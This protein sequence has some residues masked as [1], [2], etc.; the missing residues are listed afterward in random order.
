MLK[1]RN[2]PC[3]T[4]NRIG[5][6]V[7]YL[8]GLERR[9]R[10]DPKAYPRTPQ[11]E[12]ASE[13]ATDALRYI[14]E[15]NDFAQSRSA[16][17]EHMLVEGLGALEVV[18]DGDKD[19]IRKIRWDRFYH[20]PH[21]M[22]LDLSD[23]LYFGVITWFDQSRLIG[24]YPEMR[25]LIEGTMS[26]A[27]RTYT[28]TYEDKPSGKR[29]VD[30]KRRRIQ[31]FET[32]WW[33]REWQRA[34]WMRGSFLEAAAP[35]PYLDEYNI[36]EHPYVAQCAYRD[37]D[38]NPYGVVKRYKDLQDEIN[39]RRSKALH[40]L[41]ARRVITEQGSVENADMARIE[42]QKP[43]GFLEVAPGARFDIESSVDIGM[44]QF[45]LL[46]DAIQALGTTGPNAALQG[47]SG[48]ISGK[49]KQLDQEGGSVQ[50]GALFD[51]IRHLQKRTAR[52]CW[53]RVKQFWTE[54][55][56][57]R[58]T[59]DEQKVKFVGLNVPIA[60]GELQAEQLRQLPPEQKMAAVQQLAQDPMSQLHSGKRRNDV[61]EMNV[62]II[63]DE[64]PDAVT[65]QSEQFAELVKLASAGVVFP[66]E[67][68]IA[69]SGLQEQAAD[70]GT[71]QGR[72]PEVA[73]AAAARAADAAD[74]A[75][76]DGSRPRAQTGQGAARHGGSSE[77]HAVGADGG[78][79]DG[80]RG[81]EYPSGY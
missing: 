15:V 31:V 54:E 69:A 34:V 35:S 49:A 39:K 73:R 76:H 13:A 42:V 70:S 25:T 3:I 64:S 8:M 48:S 67:A 50:I 5:D 57:I 4:D 27:L 30:V 38:G 66:P 20:D 60:N 6:K 28:E 47:M 75:G 61:A 81:R 26:E 19:K 43:D 46:T 16:V 11:D 24:K 58:V 63:I 33:A 7:D 14:F 53:S 74:A 68:Y 78:G 45:Q 59:D 51:Q 71:A 41:S 18:R 2:Q 32:Y 23:A 62:D 44:S 40:A 55:T 37:R 29:F 77:G 21:S 10:T 22:E 72:D 79:Q 80:R 12:G 17:F 56:W 36:R 1:D 52:K 65:L 9:S